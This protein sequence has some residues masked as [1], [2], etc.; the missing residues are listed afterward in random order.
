MEKLSRKAVVLA[1]VIII[2]AV[3]VGG[4]EE[5]NLANT[6]KAR[7]V[8]T[9]NIDLKTQLEQCNTEAEKQKEILSEC[10]Q[11]K[12]ELTE[13][14]EEIVRE[15]VKASVDLLFDTFGEQASKL[16][17]ENKELKAQIEALQSEDVEVESPEE[18]E[19]L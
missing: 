7:I 3:F 6:K 11:V 18:G 10:Q 9:E 5:A 12:N 15:R 8:A 19:S 2:G 14:F 13:R 4:C 1:I 17:K 16:A